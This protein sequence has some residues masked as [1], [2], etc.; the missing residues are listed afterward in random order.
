ME[1]NITYREKD[2][3]I[4]VIVSY[5]DLN[6]K[7]KQKSK[8]G[9]KKKSDA[10]RHADTIIDNLKETLQLQKKL[11]TENA[12][13]TLRK[14]SDMVI[15]NRSLYCEKNTVIHYQQ[16]VDA[17]GDILDM[18][19]EDINSAH[20]QGCI[21]KLIQEGYE[22]STISIYTRIVKSL[23]KVAVK[24]YRII[25]EN[26]FTA[27]D[28]IIP[29]VEKSTE[30]KALTK[31]KLDALLED[32]KKAKNQKDYIISLIASS[33]GLRI[34][35]IEGLCEPNIIKDNPAIRVTRQWKKK[36]DGSYGFGKVKTSNSVRTVPISRNTLTEICK[37]I[38]EQKIKDI[39][40]RIFWQDK[41]TA[42]TSSRLGRKFKKKGFDISIHDLR[43]TYAT[44]L[45]GNGI[46]VRTVASLIGDT[47]EM[48]TK[49]YLHTTDDMIKRA[50]NVIE[51]IF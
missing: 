17:F 15:N 11:D 43:H 38:D 2:K 34:G 18:A 36:K 5:K 10:R 37:Y 48:V 26:P 41:N 3:G 7:W 44:M 50:S 31:S 14:F 46:D 40:K 32:L 9:F 49:T 33:A 6:G 19:M 27:G 28:I 29:K 1:Y 23:F 24:P 21:D 39:G 22:P 45:I 30:I 35:E 25:A 16:G 8:Q 47:V 4:Q 12:G 13:M 42:S 20:I 51:K